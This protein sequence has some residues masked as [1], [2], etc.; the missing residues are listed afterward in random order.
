[1]LYLGSAAAVVVVALVIVFSLRSNDTGSQSDTPGHRSSTP[2]ASASDSP[3]GK[4]TPLAHFTGTGDKTTTSFRAAANWEVRWQTASD[5]QFT[6][7]LLDKDGTSRGEIVAAKKRTQGS[8]FVSDAGEYKLKVTG[9]RN[10]S[11]QIVGRSR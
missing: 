2:T 11:L 8:V 6:V 10:W 9:S 7:E 1:M 5:K 3:S 4:P